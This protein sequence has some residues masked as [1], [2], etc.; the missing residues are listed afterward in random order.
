VDNWAHPGGLQ[1]RRRASQTG[2]RQAGI[3]VRYGRWHEPRSSCLLGGSENTAERSRRYSARSPLALDSRCGNYPKRVEQGLSPE[4][5]KKWT[6][7]SSSQFSIATGDVL[8]CLGK[9]GVTWD[10]PRGGQPS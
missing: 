5:S 3:G 10:N 6:D 2:G 7:G 9:R 4:Q 8:P 1:P